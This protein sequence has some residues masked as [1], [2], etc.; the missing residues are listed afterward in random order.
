MAWQLRDTDVSLIFTPLY[1]AGGLAAFLTP[2]LA[3]G[4]SI[5]L[6]RGFEAAEIWRTIEEKRCTLVLGVPTIW[7]LLLDAPEFLSFAKNRSR[8]CRGRIRQRRTL[9]LYCKP[10]P[11]RIPMG[12]ALVSYL[13]ANSAAT[14]GHQNSNFNPN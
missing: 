3:I 11:G 4:G 14:R 7:K 13:V 12:A 6:H 5:V 2:L 10:P 9:Q 1:H 8:L